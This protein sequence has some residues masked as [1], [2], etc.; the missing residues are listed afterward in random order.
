MSLSE[1]PDLDRQCAPL[2]PTLA[3]FLRRYLDQWRPYKAG[4]WLYEDGIVWKG[5]LDLA[6]ASGLRFPAD[7][8][9]REISARVGTDGDIAGYTAEEFNID[10][11]N[12]GRAV[13]LLWLATGEARFRSA[14][15][16]QLA[17]LNAHPRT[18][19]GNYWHKRIYPNQ[20]WLDGLYMAQPLRCAWAAETGD[21]AIVD[22][23]LAQFR[24]VRDRLGDPAN[25]LLRHG[26]DESGSERWADP[27]SG[28][29]ANVW[30]RAL[31]WYVM[32]LAD[33]VEVLSERAP[34]AADELAT[35]L[36]ETIEALLPLR[37]ERGLWYQLAALP[38]LVGNYE[39]TSASAMV[40]G[41]LMKGERLGVLDAEAGRAGEQALRAIARD[42]VD[43]LEMTGICGVAG[44]G[45]VPY[46]DGSVGYYLSEP[47][48]GNDPKGV[49][50]LMMATAQWLLR[51]AGASST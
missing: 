21:R 48:I 51:A 7:F 46:R 18:Q 1:Y 31:G 4:R 23:V 32:A 9:Y 10:N 36:Q 15:Q 13:H 19:S 24:V 40:A 5:A 2:S 3:P 20:V 35:M 43:G 17:Q 29:S 42:F 27:D 38:T 33:C 47:I 39:E 26:W 30:G 22:D 25:G 44:L 14:V 37:S 50:A 45:N 28:C 8:A 12:P 16:K 6:T 11:V 49:A 34:A 41:A